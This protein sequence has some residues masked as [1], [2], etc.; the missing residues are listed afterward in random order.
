MIETFI[1]FC[2]FSTLHIVSFTSPWL[3]F[4]KLYRESHESTDADVNCLKCTLL[5]LPNDP[6][7]PK[8]VHSR[9]PPRQTPPEGERSNLKKIDSTD[10]GVGR[11]RSGESRSKSATSVAELESGQVNEAVQPTLP[12]PVGAA[13]Y[14]QIIGNLMDLKASSSFIWSIASKA[15][16]VHT[17][18]LLLKGWRHQLLFR[19]FEHL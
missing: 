13:E 15:Q 5:L 8:G 17:S 10:S 11:D 16:N 19:D 3:V 18:T 7:Q 6:V 12:P 9:L 1:L 4:C 2:C 14:Q